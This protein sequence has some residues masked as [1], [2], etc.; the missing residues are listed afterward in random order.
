[1]QSEIYDWVLENIPK[2]ATIVEAGTYDG[3]DTRF[4]GHHFRKG[5]IYGFEPVEELY[6][7][8]IENTSQYKNVSIEKKALG[9][10]NEKK[11]IYIS[12]VSGRTSA[13]SSL[14]TP[15]EH[16]TFHENVKFSAKQEVEVV[17][18]DSWCDENKISKLDFMWLDV[19]GSE[20]D[21]IKS[22]PKII[23]NTKYLYCEVSLM[24]MYEGTIL[25]DK[26]KD[27]MKQIGFD[28]VFEELPWEDM[29]NVLFKNLVYKN[30]NTRL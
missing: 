7:R 2:N 21:I 30:E 25:Y 26:F 8:S 20:Y 12:N 14:R 15:K 18:L 24:E 27:N 23:S 3:E 13:S 6:V 9:E 1:M 5:K 4:F 16:L 29:G 22:S 11:S 28:V 10:K 19:Q 17:N